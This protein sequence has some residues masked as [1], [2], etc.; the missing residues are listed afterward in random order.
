MLGA[1]LGESTK[2]GY[3]ESKSFGVSGT[4]LGHAGQ[5]QLG[6]RNPVEQCLAHVREKAG[7]R[8]ACIVLENFERIVDKPALVEQIAD[9][10]VMLDDDAYSS[11][12]TKFLIVGVPGDLRRYFAEVPNLTTVANRLQ[13]LP[14][15]TRLTVQ[16][17]GELVTRGLFVE[18]EIQPS[19]SVASIVSHIMW[20]TDRIP[21]QVHEYCLDLA[22]CA[23]A[24]ARLVDVHA[25]SNADQRWTR[26]S[27]LSSY[28]TIEAVMNSRSSRAGRRNQTLYAIGQHDGDEFKS[29]DIESIVRDEF[30]EST[31]DVVL[32]M[33]G[34]LAD[35]SG[36][37]NAILLRTP[38]GDAYRV[39]NPKYRMCIR[40]MLR[41]TGDKV[42]KI[43]PQRLV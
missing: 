18:L 7:K 16:Q 2:V 35:L 39:R 14:E 13:E 25:I 37:A 38:R 15:V 42:E 33:S 5:Y 17:A 11:Y 20:V 40:A 31:R 21:Q 30:P 3:T 28:T 19:I 8:P 29:S 26:R 9:I 12:R 36:G 32:N 41:K 6:R 22:T 4:S 43:D 34:V 23:I 10:L 1:R 24:R 27:L